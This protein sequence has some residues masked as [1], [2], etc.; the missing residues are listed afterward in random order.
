MTDVQANVLALRYA[1]GPIKA[2]WS[3]RGKVR[4]L[5]QFWVAE[6]RAQQK[7]GIPIP[8]EDIEAYEYVIDGID[9]ESIADRELTLKH[10]VLANLREF[11]HRASLRAVRTL[12]WAHQG[13]TSRDPTDNVE[14]MQVL[15][16]LELIKAKVA[17]VL[18]RLRKRMLEYGTLDIAGRSHLVIGQT[19]THGKRLSYIAEEM[20][21]VGLRPLSFLINNYPLRGIKGPMG[22][23][24]DMVK[25]LKSA[26]NAM[27]LED[28]MRKHLGFQEI[29]V[30]VGQT[31][32]RSLD[33]WT[34]STLLQVGFAAG[35]FSNLIRLMA[36]LELAHEG[37]GD[38]Q[39]GSSAMPHKVNSRTCERIRS[40]LRILGGHTV[41][42]MQTA[43]DQWFE[44][45]VSC[46]AVRRVA[47]SDA[48]YAIDGILESMLHVLDEM[49]I[50]PQMIKRELDRYLPI[51]S[52]TGLLMAA[53]KNGMGREDAHSI[54]GEHAR[55]V[56]KTWREGRDASLIDL[57]SSDGRFLVSKQEMFEI[58]AKPDHG[59]ADRHV[60]EVAVMIKRELE[61]FSPEDLNYHPEVML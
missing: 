48:F 20:V 46:S 5:R 24:Q 15:M 54:I 61:G 2:I 17:A 13:N 4:Y 3:D 8:D 26:P 41:M 18:E 47:L 9:L 21:R 39:E 23:Q 12:Q 58:I 7:L 44:G 11:N 38:E 6:M 55:A 29:F 50:F 16:S 43:G 42:L 36:G 27:E 19:T 31:Y 37:F 57:L 22:T 49:Q 34:V 35:N 32:P 56:V 45:D 10:D 25:H 30:S 53:V 33:Y 40:L 52:T 14:Q 60:A 28:H 51:L 59:L 1:S